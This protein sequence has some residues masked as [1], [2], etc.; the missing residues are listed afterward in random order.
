[1]SRILITGANGFIGSFLVE[2]ALRQ[3]H[4]VYAGVRSS[5]NLKYLDVDRTHILRLDLSDREKLKQEWKK[6]D[7]PAFDYV[8]HNAGATQ[9]VEPPDFD[10]INNQYTQNLLES[11]VEA[12]FAPK[13]FILMSSLAAMGPGDAKSMLPIEPSDQPA[14]ITHYGRSKLRVEEYLKKQQKVPYLIFRPTAVYGPRD[15]DFLSLF[16]AIQKHIEPYI[17]SPNQQLSF[18]YVKDLARLLIQSTGS[19]VSNGSFFVSDGETYTCRQL[20]KISKKALGKW[21]FPLV[22]PRP[23]LKTIAL[24]SEKAAHARCKTSLLNSDKYKELTSLNWACN[25]RET[26]EAFNFTPQ[27]DLEAGIASSIQWYRKNKQL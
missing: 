1:M 11:L 7:I 24:L 13:K 6:L 8:I 19:S 12:K 23:L 22:I 5:S 15:K 2:E 25:S 18:I 27:Y 14:P 9:V 26:L 10:R 3:K 4:E 21:T 20:S 17:S 16:K